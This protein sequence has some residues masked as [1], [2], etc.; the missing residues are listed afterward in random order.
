MSLFY[1]T[2]PRTQAHPAADARK[3]CQPAIRAPKQGHVDVQIAMT[4][5]LTLK[6]ALAGLAPAS[7]RAPWR[8]QAR[9]ALG[10]GLAVAASTSVAATAGQ[11]D[12]AGAFLVASIGSSA[13]LVIG[14]PNSPMSQ[15]WPL[16]VGN[17][18]AAL[19]GVAAGIAVP[20]VPLACGL[21]LAAAVFFMHAA[22][23]L[24][25]PAGG[26]AL[27]GVLSV[28]MSD[29]GG[30][31]FALAPVALDSVLLL[32]FAL[33]WS[34][35]TGRVYPFRQ[36][37]AAAAPGRLSEADLEAILARLRLSATLGAGDFARLLAAADEISRADDRVAGLT[38]GATL[39]STGH[40]LAALAPHTGADEA[41]AFLL[42]SHL[43]SAPVLDAED[44]LLGLLSQSDLLRADDAATVAAEIMT[45]HPVTVPATAPL[46]D[47]MAALATGQFRAVPVMADDG[48]CLGLL[49][50]ADVLAALAH[51]RP[52]SR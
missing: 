48:R 40:P 52:G 35:A 30:F 14:V 8:E 24:H 10:S 12:M 15:P 4:R 46:A 17:T 32:I 37:D 20:I 6:R 22:R 23:A 7:A 28:G 13:F 21:A 51:R 1:P 36:A 49:T 42:E 45:R 18:G 25:P 50:R 3:G 11:G 9:A 19:I 29:A 44:R 27:A 43:Y 38:C 34:A 26:V 39:L 41:R 31:G 2:L 33:I 5:R 16:V 47:G